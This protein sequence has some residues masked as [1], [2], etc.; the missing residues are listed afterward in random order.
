MCTVN[1]KILYVTVYEETQRY[2]GPEEGGW[3]YWEGLPMWTARGIC[4][5]LD[6][7]LGFVYGRHES[8]CPIKRLMLEAQAIV[9][10]VPEGY[11]GS[12][13]TQD[14]DIPEYRNEA[15]YG[16]RVLKQQEHE[17]REYPEVQPHYE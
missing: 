13:I 9:T 8:H 4:L 14:A 2:G 11:L 15:V 7:A 6:A 12:F 17:A 10:A 3:Y 5:C 16:R 1:E